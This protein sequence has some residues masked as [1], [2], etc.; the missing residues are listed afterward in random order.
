V[1]LAPG[2]PPQ[3]RVDPEVLQ[4][5]YENAGDGLLLINRARRIVMMNPAA[6]QI[7]GWQGRDLN[8]INCTVFNCR[9]EHGKKTCD[10]GCLAQRCV[11]TG[12]Q[13][14]P[15]FLR[16]GRAGGG[17]SSVEATFMPPKSGVGACM[18]LLK[19]ITVLEGLDAQVRRLN[20][21]IAEKNIVLRG[22][23]DQMSTAWRSAMIDL[24]G[25]AEG[26]RSRYGRELG[27]AGM[28]LTDRM[29][30]ATQKLEQTFA[31]LKS[32]IQSATQAKQSPKV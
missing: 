19:D 2:G 20:G 7:T 4:T 32:Q 11:E 9:D 14:G 25:S 26:L 18:L 8:S 22:F 17:T 15:M 29:I 31:H 3:T 5:F 24:R 23:S 16:I 21:E 27:D 13:I 1:S 28:K 30:L 12:Q 10:D 6:T